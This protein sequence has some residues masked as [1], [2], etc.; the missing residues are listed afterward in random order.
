M[1]TKEKK[2]ILAP[3]CVI[4]QGRNYSCIY[5]LQRN[6]IYR[7]PNKY[8]S[9]FHKDLAG[10]EVW[11]ILTENSSPQE[12][13]FIDSL[14]ENQLCVATSQSDYFRPLGTECY[15]ERFCENAIIDRD[16]ESVFS[17]EEVSKKLSLVSCAAI[18]L[19]YFYP[20]SIGVI[21]SDLR[22][23]IDSTVRYIE[24]HCVYSGKFSQVD[25]P[26]FKRRNGRV[27]AFIFYLGEENKTIN[28]GSDFYLQFKRVPMDSSSTCG[29]VSMRKMR[30]QTQLYIESKNYNNCLYRKVYID[31]RGRVRN[32]P[33]TSRCYGMIDDDKLRLNAVLCSSEFQE[34]WT[35]TKDVIEECQDCEFRY[36]CIDCRCSLQEPGNIYSKP[37][38]CQYIP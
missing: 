29:C 23:F 26:E 25:F 32:C 33:G 2:I 30:A 38:K 14:K 20:A 4:V 27:G 3:C 31:S 12:R 16:E 24:V 35:L 13:E 10:R 18:S 9:I 21:E 28:Q 17:M 7:F 36:A 15:I 22:A 37:S 8:L 1:S 5:D 19:R 11:T 6:G 34:Y